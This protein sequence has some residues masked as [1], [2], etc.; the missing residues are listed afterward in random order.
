MHDRGHTEEAIKVTIDCFTAMKIIDPQK[1]DADIILQV[2][3]TRLTFDPAKKKFHRVRLIQK[4]GNSFI[5][6]H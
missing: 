2:L 3:P 6:P 1:K 4:E 5:N